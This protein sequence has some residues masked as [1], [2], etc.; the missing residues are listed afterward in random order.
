MFK[1]KSLNKGFETAFLYVSRSVVFFSLYHVVCI[2]GQRYKLYISER[3]FQ[4]YL[5]KNKYKKKF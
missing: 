5:K 4:N 2:T 1:G 3:N